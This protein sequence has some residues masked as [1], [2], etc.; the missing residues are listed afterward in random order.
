MSF[1]GCRGRNT[2]RGSS[3]GR[4]SS[5]VSTPEARAR[6]EAARAFAQGAAAAAAGQTAGGAAG[7]ATALA[8]TVARASGRIVAQ[9]LQWLAAFGLLTS[10]ALRQ[11]LS[12]RTRD[13]RFIR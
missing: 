11:L 7:A 1:S 3:V 13:E 5:G 8:A 4:K 12:Q 2:P 9:F 10:D 6:E